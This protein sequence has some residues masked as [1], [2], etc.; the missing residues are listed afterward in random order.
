[1]KKFI[2]YIILGIAFVMFVFTSCN[3]AEQDVSPIASPDGYPVA[4]FTTNNPGS[5]VT[6]GDTIVYTITTDKALDRALTF[7]V[8]LKG[9]TADE[10]DI[11][12]ANAVISPYQTSTTIS[13]VI[14][15]DDIPEVAE[16]LSLEVGVFGLADRYLLNPSTVN[17]NLDLTINNFNDPGFFTIAFAWSTPDDDYDIH[18]YSELGGHWGYSGTADNPELNKHLWDADPDGNYSFSIEPYDF[19]SVTTDYTISIG[20]TDQT[21]QFFSGTFDNSKYADYIEDAPNVFRLLDIVKVGA[22]YTVTQSK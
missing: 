22:S 19:T 14:K 18:I 15:A 9:G 16:T 20:Y 4:T 2:Q 7:S 6:E 11:E 17:P 3:T 13:I 8:K 10:S 12:T 5:T 21:V 1:M